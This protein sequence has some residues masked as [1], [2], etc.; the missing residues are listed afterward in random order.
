MVDLQ[1]EDIQGIIVTGYGHLIYSSYIFLH[2]DEPTQAKQWLQ[3][4]AADM[5]TAKWETESGKQKPSAALNIA[6]TCHGLAKLGLPPESL[7]TFSEEFLQGIA[8]EVRANRFG[9]THDS[10][11]QHWEICAGI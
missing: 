7:N 10:D 5:T 11:P 6:F 3:K 4:I 2:I 1:T 9:D 8:T